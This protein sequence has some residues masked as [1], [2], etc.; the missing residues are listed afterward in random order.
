MTNAGN[1]VQNALGFACLKKYLLN[2]TYIAI[3]AWCAL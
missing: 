1:M 3:N 2:L